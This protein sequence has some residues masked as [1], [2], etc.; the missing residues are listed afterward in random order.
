MKRSEKK[1][2]IAT[3]ALALAGVGIATYIAISEAGGGAPAC[4]AGSTGCATVADSA[5]SEVAGVNVAVIGIAGYAAIAISALLPGDPGRLGGALLAMIG[6][7]YTLY[8][9]YLE[10]FVIEAVCQWCVA[11]AVT[12]TALLVA[13]SW[14]ALLYGG[15]ESSG[16][17]E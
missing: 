13:A 3:L 4:I 10:L 9:T 1:L 14:R 16:M 7:G 11:S 6:F 15:R 17:R 2:R 8:L 12:M 5:Y